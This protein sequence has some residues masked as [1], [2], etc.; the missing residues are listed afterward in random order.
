MKIASIDIG[1]NTVILLIAEIRHQRIVTLRNEYKV[2][3]IGKSLLRNKLICD[4]KIQELIA[5]VIHE[6]GSDLHLGAGRVPAIRVSGEL[7]FLL[8]N[9]VLTKEDMEGILSAIL[10]KTKLDKFMSEQEMDFSY[11]YN[12]E[13]R[14]RGNAF[15][16]KGLINIALRLVPKVK[17]LK[18]LHLP[19]IIA[20]IARKKQGFFL[21]RACERTFL[22]GKQ[23]AQYWYR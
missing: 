1:T 8:K 23:N 11:D 3:R 21:F 14:L 10:D 22:T 18:E 12:G 5:T 15:F 17:P 13:T 19:E 9:P 16:Q 6:N 4:E 2:P 7:I 20:E